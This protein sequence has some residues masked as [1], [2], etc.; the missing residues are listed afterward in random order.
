MLGEDGQAR[1]LV[2]HIMETKTATMRDVVTSDLFH[3]VM[4]RQAGYMTASCM[5][6]FG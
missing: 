4:Q 1:L 5:S 2:D 3:R 6:I